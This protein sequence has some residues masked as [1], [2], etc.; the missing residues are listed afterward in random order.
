[1]RSI[2]KDDVRNHIKFKISGIDIRSLKV[3]SKSD[4]L[5]KRFLVEVSLEF[6]DSVINEKFWPSGVRVRVFKGNGKNWSDCE[7]EIIEGV[8]E[9]VNSDEIIEEVSE[10]ADNGSNS[11]GSS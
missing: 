8:S 4:S 1:M 9:D 2:Q 7:E 11:E 3:M 6:Y 10:D 5:Y